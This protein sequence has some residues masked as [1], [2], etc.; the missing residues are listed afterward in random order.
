MRPEAVRRAGGTVATAMCGL[1]RGRGSRTARMRESES[2][3]EG[4]IAPSVSSCNIIIPL[5][6]TPQSETVRQSRVVARTARY[7]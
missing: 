4:R 5:P 7:I 1:L 3:V 2:V 6:I